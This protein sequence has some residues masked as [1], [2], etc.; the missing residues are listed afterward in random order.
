MRDR[1]GRKPHLPEIGGGIIKRIVGIIIHANYA[2]KMASAWYDPDL[3]APK[4]DE[5][6]PKGRFT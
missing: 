1:N 3:N 4:L 5:V 2:G 6:L